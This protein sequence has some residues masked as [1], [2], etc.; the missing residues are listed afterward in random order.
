MYEEAGLGECAR[1]PTPVAGTE[2]AW[3]L[4]VIRHAKPYV[5]ASALKDA[6]IGHKIYY[7]TPVHRQPAMLARYGD[8]PDLPATEAVAGEHLA[9][10]MGP[11]LTSSQVMEVVAAVRAVAL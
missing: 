4:Y 1:L 9:I 11:S 5:L 6:G 8:G 7:R 2:P 10:P 3:H